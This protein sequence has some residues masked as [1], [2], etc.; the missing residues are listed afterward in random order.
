MDAILTSAVL[1]LAINHNDPA[2]ARKAFND[3][4][5]SGGEINFD[6]FIA[7]LSY[8]VQENED[9]K[10]ELAELDEDGDENND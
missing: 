8:A 4:I 5:L 7:E 2:V 10:Q 3:H 9:F 1:F 6:N